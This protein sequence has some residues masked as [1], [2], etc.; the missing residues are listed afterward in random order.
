MKIIILD[1]AYPDPESDSIGDPFVHVRAKYFSETMEVVV[2]KTHQKERLDYTFDGIFVKCTKGLEEFEEYLLGFNPQSVVVHFVEP[3]MYKIA[4][5]KHQFPTFIWVHGSEA[6]AW[7]R[8]LF[9]VHKKNYKKF[10][11]EYL[12][13]NLHSLRNFRNV[14]RTSNEKGNPRLI[15]VSKWMKNVASKDCF[16]KIKDFDVVPNPIDDSIFKYKKKEEDDRLKILIIRSF[17]SPKYANDISID[18]ILKLSKEPFFKELKFT[19]YG[20][21]ILFEKLTNKVSH[22]DNIE[23]NNVFLHQ[24]EIKELHD[25]HGIF[26]CPTR[27]DAQGVSMCEAMSSGLV[28][29]TSNNTAIPEY[30]NSESGIL[31]NNSEDIYKG[32]K[33]LYNNPLNYLQLSKQASESILAQCG[34]DKV[35]KREISIIGA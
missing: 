32:I 15:F 33:F 28:P 24:Q 2:L 8:I 27:M 10:F 9:S 12:Y 29:I 11:T 35:M 17:N 19:I 30:V 4:I 16:I 18:A 20:K 5:L 13:N 21:G 14:V 31:T 34:I 7:Y 23:I 25:S 3:W 22:L 6:L 26:L 1:Q